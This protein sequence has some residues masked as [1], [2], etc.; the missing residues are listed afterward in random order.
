MGLKYIRD[1]RRHLPVFFM[2]IVVAGLYLTWTWTP[3]L[4]GFG[5]DNAYYVL[6]ARYFSP[7]E[8]ASGVA[9]YFA[10]HSPYPPLYPLLLALSGGA[11]NLLLAHLITTLFL[12]TAF[13]LLYR[14]VRQLGLTAAVAGGVTAAFA[15]LPGTYM[16]ALYLHS[17]NLF[18]LL[19]LLALSLTLRGETTRSARCFLGAAVVIAG[20]VLTRSAGIALLGAWLVY[21]PLRR[22][23]YWPRWAAAAAAPVLLWVIFSN[24]EGPHYLSSLTATYGADIYAELLAHLKIQVMALKYAWVGNLSGGGNNTLL[25]CAVMGVICL[26]G[27]LARLR[28]GALDGWYVLLYLVMIFIWPFPGEAQRF[29]FA[30]QPVLLAQGVGL[31]A[32]LPSVVMFGRQQVLVAG[33]FPAA[34]LLL[35]APDLALTIQRFRTGMPAELE[36]LRRD[37]AWYGDTMAGSLRRVQFERGLIDNLRTL[38]HFVPEEECIFAIKPSIVGLYTERVA[39]NP[40]R[41]AVGDQAF[42]QEI[43]MTNCHYVY[44][45]PFSSPSFPA[46]YPYQRVRPSLRVVTGYQTQTS[47]TPVIGVLGRLVLPEKP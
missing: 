9:R 41:E 28:A 27:A 47:P 10:T 6:I 1:H 40:P 23:P 21:L 33:L 43:K 12:L 25:I 18:L 17:E 38:N 3:E 39:L 19:S 8:P 44:L 15:V 7:Y 29:V 36:S 13:G 45:L 30:I 24:H 16:Q 26:A 35:A 5:G 42:W 46:F 37:P 11:Y 2:S 31:L 34:L 32:R 4:V 14:F 20:A 22:I